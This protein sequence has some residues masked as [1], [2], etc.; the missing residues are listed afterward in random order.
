MRRLMLAGLLALPLTACSRSSRIATLSLPS[1]P[2]AA[3][4]QCLPA[5]LNLMQLS[6]AD[7]ERVIRLSDAAVAQCEGK[8]RLLVDA[9]PKGNAK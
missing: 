1:P 3:L 2:D 6:S 5:P 7:V 9:S 4:N 8:R